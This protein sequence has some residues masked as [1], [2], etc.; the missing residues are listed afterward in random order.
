MF[1]L[2]GRRFFISFAKALKHAL[3]LNLWYS[4]KISLSQ[5][6]INIGFGCCLAVF[7]Q[8]FIVNSLGQQVECFS[9]R[10]EILIKMQ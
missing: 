1:Y 10:A 3:W 4:V 6:N 2:V 7:K 9:F 8:N 5:K